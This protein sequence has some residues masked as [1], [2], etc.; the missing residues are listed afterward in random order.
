MTIIWWTLYIIGAIT[1]LILWINLMAI[2]FRVFTYILKKEWC[3]VKVIEGPQGPVGP[4]GKPG[5]DREFDITRDV[6]NLLTFE[7]KNIMMNYGILTRKDIESLVRMEISAQLSKYE[8]LR[9]TYPA[10][11]KDQFKIQ[12]KEE[13]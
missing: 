5:K 1:I 3:K 13:K 2:I 11:G 6:Q 9:E 8:I 4:P 7:V 12:E 10:L